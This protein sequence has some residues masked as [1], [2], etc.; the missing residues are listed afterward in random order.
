MMSK[1]W[2]GSVTI[3]IECEDKFWFDQV[4]TEMCE[5][6][7]EHCRI[8]NWEVVEQYIQKE[9]QLKDKRS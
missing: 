8:G 3:E 5:N 9:H 4:I 7:R 6:L 2:K 1:L